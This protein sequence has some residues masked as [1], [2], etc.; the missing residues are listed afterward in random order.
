MLQLSIP[1]PRLPGRQDIEIEMSVNGD[2]QKMH[3]IMHLYAWEDCNAPP[4]GRV[5]CIRDLVDLYGDE[6]MLY[7]I[8]LPTEN[9]VP[10]TF[11]K[12]ADWEQQRKQIRDAVM[13]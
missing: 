8:G 5:N 2:K 6:W 3:F 1:I 12:V 11:V 9:Y 4:E 7:N 10:L 13:N